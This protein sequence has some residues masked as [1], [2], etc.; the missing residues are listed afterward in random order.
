VGR[1]IVRVQGD[2]TVEHLCALPKIPRRHPRQALPAAQVVLI[3]HGAG[4]RPRQRLL[5]TRT[6]HVA[7]QR[8][9]H[10]V[11]NLG[12]DCEDLR[13]RA[14]ES[15]RPPV[16]ARGHFHQLHGDSQVVARLAHAALEQRPHS[17]RATD[18][19]D[20]G[21]GPSVLEGSRSR[22]HA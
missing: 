6:Q 21:T 4:L 17:Q 19:A 22:R 12:L 3:R 10:A 1:R 9:R 5:L 18:L 20:V 15:L 16:M 8:R 2:R 7:T 11:R 13:E 14:I